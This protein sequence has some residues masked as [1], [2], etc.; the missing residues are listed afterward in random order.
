MERRI[1]HRLARLAQL[2]AERSASNSSL[3][4][5]PRELLVQV[6]SGLS[7]Q[8]LLRFGSCSRFCR[9]TVR[10]CEPLWVELCKAAA[11]RP[12]LADESA[13]LLYKRRALAEARW[14]RGDYRLVELRG[15]A[16]RLITGHLFIG[17]DG[18]RQV[19]TMDDDSRCLLWDVERGDCL[20]SAAVPDPSELL[21]GFASDASNW[22]CDAKHFLGVHN[23]DTIVIYG[24]GGAQL[25]TCRGHTRPITCFGLLH[26]CVE[27][28]DAPAVCGLWSVPKHTTRP[29][30]PAAG[31]GAAAAAAT[32]AISGSNDGTCRVWSVPTGE[33]LAV[34]D[35]SGE[36][37]LDDEGASRGGVLCM[38]LHQ[39]ARVCV[40]GTAAGALELFTL[41]QC[42][43]RPPPSPLLPPPPEVDVSRRRVAAHDGAVLCIE[44]DW[45]NS[46]IVT[47]SRDGSAKVWRVQP[48]SSSCA[49]EGETEPQSEVWSVAPEV[50]LLATLTPQLRPLGGLGMAGREGSAPP[51]VRSVRVDNYGVLTVEGASALLWDFGGDSFSRNGAEEEEST[52]AQLMAAV[53]RRR[54]RRRSVAAS[55]SPLRR[56]RRRSSGRQAGSRSPS[57]DLPPNPEAA[58]ECESEPESEPEPQPESEPEPEPE[59]ERDGPQ[60]LLLSEADGSRAAALND[61]DSGDS[62]SDSSDSSD[63]DTEALLG[64]DGAA[65]RGPLSAEDL[66]VRVARL[67]RRRDR[68][69]L[70]EAFGQMNRQ[71][72]ARRERERARSRRQDAAANHVDGDD[73]AGSGGEMPRGGSDAIREV[74]R[75]LAEGGT[76]AVLT[77]SGEEGV[78]GC[79]EG[80]RQGYRLVY[81]GTAD[82]GAEK[83][84]DGLAAPSGSAVATAAGSGSDPG[85]AAGGGGG[86]GG[87]DASQLVVALFAKASV[88]DWAPSPEEPPPPQQQQP[89]PPQQQLGD[90]GPAAGGWMPEGP[91]Q[92]GRLEA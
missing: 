45:A 5:L 81:S 28:K 48:P 75:M 87:G 6:L 21:P 47:G 41:D 13:R 69:K 36:G 1:G 61:V 31:D 58:A 32:L 59:P 11:V 92:R 2:A 35:T 27:Q 79:G 42:R 46:R 10:D 57:P 12:E 72:R 91:E 14:R 68:K 54:Q 22:D 40:A 52:E 23:R 39:T 86:G 62:D 71:H 24:G 66:D 78:G 60:E 88:R 63:S 3:T 73:G 33:T 84:G 67:R 77:G 65:L 8:E 18:S 89:P 15:N 76:R 83:R 38:T 53:A 4:L 26:A 37:E 43:P 16:T 90:G 82:D 30:S 9:S 56:Q 64:G 49:D 29:V 25:A 17:A 55:F 34:I 80:G 50:V 51:P 70:W 20:G 7:P 19:L 44:A 85:G 74:D